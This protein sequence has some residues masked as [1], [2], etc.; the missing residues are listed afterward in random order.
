MSPKDP[1]STSHADANSDDSEGRVLSDQVLQ[2]ILES[3]QIASI[4]LDGALRIRRFTPEVANIYSLT[5]QDIGRPL[6]EIATR[7]ASVPP[8]PDRALLQQ[9]ALNEVAFTNAVGQ[10]LIR[11]VFPSHDHHGT[12]TG[13]V[14][15][16]TDVTP[17]KKSEE[18]LS[19]ALQAKGMGVFEWD[20][21]SGH[22]ELSAQQRSLFDMAPDESWD[23]K[24]F[25]SLVHPNDRSRIR[26]ELDSAIQGKTEYN[27]QFRIVRRDGTE[28]WLGGHATVDRDP[29]GH[30]IR[31]VG[32]NWDTTE[33]VQRETALRLRERA[34]DSIQSGIAISD[35]TG[36]DQPI[37][38]VNRGFERMTGYSAEEVIGK[39][40]RFLQGPAT[41]RQATGEIRQAL[42]DQRECSVTL[43]N[44]RKDG[45]TFWNEVRITPVADEQGKVSHFVGTQHDVTAKTE[46][47]RLLRRILNSLFTFAAVC[48]P[49]GTL[50]EVNQTALKVAQLKP[51][52]VI[53]K[54]FADI[55]WWSYDSAIQEKLRTA[56]EDAANGTPSRFNVPIRISEGKFVTIDFQIVPMRDDGGNITHLIP[57]AIDIS[58]RLKDREQ[59]AV[60]GTMAKQSTDFIGIWNLDGQGIFLNPAGRRLVGLSDA[61]PINAINVKDYFFAESTPQVEDVIQTCI[62]TGQC[63]T[64]IEFKHFQTGEAIHVLWDVFRIDDPQTEMPFAIGTITRDVRKQKEDARRLLEA[65]KKADAA[66]RSKSEFLANMSHEIRTPMTAILGFADLL[67]DSVGHDENQYLIETIQENGRHL[68]QII[69]D[70]L[71]LSK[72][73]S[74]KLQVSLLACSPSELVAEVAKLMRIRAQQKSLDLT[75]E[76]DSSV[77]TQI[78]SDALRIKQ[79][80]INLVSNAIKFTDQG[81]VQIRLFGD[82]KSHQLTFE[83]R[84]SGIGISA[85]SLTELFQPFHQVDGSDTRSIGGTGLGLAISRRLAKRLQGRI[86]VSSELGAGSRFSLVL[87]LAPEDWI[88][89]P[90]RTGPKTVSRKA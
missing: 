48:T 18:R 64:E 24:R 67:Q 60:L 27:T 35:A 13:I 89:H 47:E 78:R 53:G 28:R 50:I 62:H 10:S 76:I 16:F 7:D 87:D 74:G 59:L 33:A 32:M 77:P 26:S 14:L 8:L 30:A 65:R 90:V 20:L 15:T 17:L 72:I 1:A 66:N 11:R 22:L 68:L 5:D 85:S 21:E 6:A 75:T 43:L 69:N 25:I 51:E 34:I 44:Y 37:R 31:M 23:L 54:P 46:S 61:D 79:I 3:Q 38:Y 41:S 4:I 81:Q 39:N 9:Q 36:K 82:P 71:D 80:L 57:S 63:S 49:D 70:I 52:E 55:Y 88:Q 40:C 29:Q 58:E 19:L 73:E 84:D 12:L 83:V 86:E 2:N 42:E 56:I 45:S